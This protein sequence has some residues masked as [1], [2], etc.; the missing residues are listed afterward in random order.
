M[1]KRNLFLS[2][3]RAIF[4]E[5]PEKHLEKMFEGGL[6]TSFRIN[7]LKSKSVQ[8]V[9][10]T[11]SEKNIELDPCS[12]MPLAF[13]LRNET[14]RFKLI[15][16]DLF[17]QGEIFIQNPSSYVPVL[18]LDPQRSETI[19]DMC[20]SPGGKTSLIAAITENESNLI[21]NDKNSGRITK[22]MDVLNLLGV[23]TR[24]VYC[25]PAEYLW[26][27]EELLSEQ[28][29]KILLDAQCTDMSQIECYRT[30]IRCS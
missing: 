19:L 8:Q 21:V 18:A 11:L 6:C 12:W 20:A 24:Q 29:D 13:H 14:D 22:L 2:R 9:L 4:S 28:F 1:R 15:D 26:K 10:S 16:S 17:I 3:L 27:K 7:P 30:V 25:E 5:V 23:K